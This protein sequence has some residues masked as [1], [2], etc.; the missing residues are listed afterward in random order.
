MNFFNLNYEE[1][2][3]LS[4]HA[5]ILTSC[6]SLKTRGLD[7]VQIKWED[8]YMICFQWMIM[9]LTFMNHKKLFGTEENDSSRGKA[10][11]IGI[12]HFISLDEIDFREESSFRI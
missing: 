11:E 6:T 9:S 8:Q 4:V 10:D 12:L 3:L 5:M 7:H 1:V 2:H